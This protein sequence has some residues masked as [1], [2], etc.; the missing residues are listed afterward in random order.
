MKCANRHTKRRA[1]PIRLTVWLGVLMA[2]TATFAQKATPPNAT[3]K[4]LSKTIATD[5]DQRLF[6]S[7][8]SCNVKSQQFVCF[9][10]R[11]AAAIEGKLQTS[12]TETMP[13]AAL[14]DTDKAFLA[15]QRNPALASC[16]NTID[17][18]ADARACQRLTTNGTAIEKQQAMRLGLALQWLQQRQRSDF[19]RMELPSA[20]SDAANSC[21]LKLPDLQI[22]PVPVGWRQVS[23]YLSRATSCIANR[24]ICSSE[25]SNFSRES[26]KRTVEL[27]SG[28]EQ[29]V[30]AEDVLI[31]VG[32]IDSDL[33]ARLT[34]D[35]S[36]I[37]QFEQDRRLI[38]AEL[39]EQAAKSPDAS[40]VSSKIGWVEV[41]QLQQ[42]GD[43]GA[44][45]NTAVF[46]RESQNVVAT[47]VKDAS[48]PDADKLPMLIE[49]VAQCLNQR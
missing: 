11:L 48:T 17:S 42:A 44:Q 7:Y 19:D 37:G 39:L 10:D 40:V 25:R 5:A 4:Y 41:L 34:I 9:R 2:S 14:A 15:A 8:Q 27:A 1:V 32:Q 28:P 16:A 13:T 12:L 45:V 46:F 49:R 24:P 23:D 33:R 47:L 43:A 35:R 31:N 29:I 30:V 6:G 18:D 21:N 38:R 26:G 22:R 36:R 3:A 20:V